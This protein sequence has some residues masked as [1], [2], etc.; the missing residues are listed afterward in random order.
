MSEQGS[1]PP[2]VVPPTPQPAAP[3]NQPAETNP[4]TGE[5]V[6]QPTTFRERQLTKLA[7]ERRLDV[8]DN[9]DQPNLQHQDIPQQTEPLPDAHQ[10]EIQGQS[11]PAPTGE[12]LPE[13]VPTN[14]PI[15]PGVELTPTPDVDLPP[16]GSVDWESR[17]NEAEELR[18]NMQSDYQRKTQKIANDRRELK[19]GFEVQTQVSAA[20]VTQAEQA[21]SKWQGVDWQGLRRTLDPADY[22]QRVEQFRQVATQVESA[23]SNHQALVD[24]AGKTLDEQKSSEAD[25]S[26]DI[27]KNTIPKWGNE[28]Y[29]QL[30]NFAVDSLGYSATEFDDVTDHKVI[31]LI[32][33]HWSTSNAGKTVEQLTRQSNQRPPQGGNLPQRGHDGKFLNTKSAWLENPGQRGRAHD[34]F[35]EKLRQEREGR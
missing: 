3:L 12:V 30:R 26:K 35:T 9:R 28:L 16:E 31:A 20:Y 29:G 24:Y 34:F 15:E 22:N 19:R 6:P 1:P 25:V 7:G 10:P 23:K 11:E 4:L 21:L 8:V 17:Y 2:A 32:H 33:R 27:L 5:S 13:P 14:E 18:G